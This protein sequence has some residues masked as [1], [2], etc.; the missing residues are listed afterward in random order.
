[1]SHE[2]PINFLRPLL[3]QG[4]LRFLL[5]CVAVG[6]ILVL[7]FA[8]PAWH[9][10]GADIL[11]GA[12]VPAMAPIIFILMM[13][14]VLMC[15]VWKSDSSDEIEIARLAFTIKTHLAVGGVLILLW[16]ASFQDALF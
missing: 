11:L 10:K 9:P 4:V 1:M 12:V 3:Q 5:Q 13:L 15:V 7:P 6:F 2:M 16:I 8:E 14:D